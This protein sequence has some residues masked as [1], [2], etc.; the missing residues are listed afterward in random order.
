MAKKEELFVG[1][2]IGSSKICVTV[3]KSNEEGTLDIIGVGTSNLTGLSKGTVKEIEDTV[4]GISEAIEIAERMAG[5]NL[6]HATVNINGGHV[7]SIISQGVAAVGR[8]DKEVSYN[9]VLRAE[10]A[11]QAL[12]IPP[13]KEINDI[14]PRHFSVDDQTGIMDPI[15]MTGV[16]LEVEANIIVVSALETSKVNKCLT[17]AGV[18]VDQSIISP[19]AASKSILTKRQKELGCAVIDIGSE[20]TGLAVFEEGSLLYTKVFSKGDINSAFGAAAVTYDLNSGLQASS[21]IDIAE[22]VKIKFG[23]AWAA[24]V[25]EKGKIDL[26]EIDIKAEGVFTRKYVAEICESRMEEIFQ[27]V[28]H[29]LKRINR[30]TKLP[31]GVILTG[32]GSKLPGIEKLA[33]EVFKLPVEVGKPHL[34]GGMTEKVY[35]PRMSVSVG[36]ALYAFEEGAYQNNNAPA[37]QGMKKIRKIIKTFLP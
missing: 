36:L 13:N 10:E 15:G 8:A 17:Q 25:S 24:D 12:Q 9:D 21:N 11:A 31:A 18:R 28:H 22:K 35:D 6:D 33:K 34:L 7:T 19:L 1:L 37:G 29:E 27:V 32:G 14:I 20:T 23:H 26:S 4:S 3:G 2:D 30:D 5:V 16:R